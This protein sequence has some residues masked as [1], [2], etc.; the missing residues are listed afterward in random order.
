MNILR[1]VHVYTYTILS[2][3]LPAKQVMCITLPPRQIPDIPAISELPGLLCLQLCLQ[4]FH[5]LN[6]LFSFAFYDLYLVISFDP[7]G[8]LTPESHCG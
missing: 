2:A 5:A 6:L 4:L 7:T 3:Q 1:R 8:G